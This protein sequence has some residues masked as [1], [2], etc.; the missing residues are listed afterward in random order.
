[1]YDVLP[2]LAFGRGDAAILLKKSVIQHKDAGK[3]VFA[4]HHMGPEMW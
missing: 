1:M 3:G 4:A 2:P